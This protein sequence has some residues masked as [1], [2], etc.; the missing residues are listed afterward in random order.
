MIS[1]LNSNTLEN[2]EGTKEA[3]LQALR[4]R[5]IVRE[6]LTKDI[7]AQYSTMGDGDDFDSPSWALMQAHK[8]GQIKAFKKIIAYFE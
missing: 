1:R 5:K 8:M 3:Y 7:E 6:I 4:F 2:E